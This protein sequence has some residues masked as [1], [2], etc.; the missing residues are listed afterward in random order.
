ME[1]AYTKDSWK[2][3]ADLGSTEDNAK[4]GEIIQSITGEDL[5]P[6]SSVAFPLRAWIRTE[7]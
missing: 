3:R 4:L 1:Y 7:R 5:L 2:V 6:H